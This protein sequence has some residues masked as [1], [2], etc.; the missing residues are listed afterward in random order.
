[1][2]VK[3]KTGK[4]LSAIDDQLARWKEHFQETLNRPL[5][6]DPPQLEPGLKLNVNKGRITKKEIRKAL[7]SLKKGKAAGVDNI[8][9][10]ALQEG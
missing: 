6:Q 1:M 9:A 8:T 7:N 5:P 10:E 2:P 3:D 4:L